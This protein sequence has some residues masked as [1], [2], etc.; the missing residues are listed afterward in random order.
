VARPVTLSTSEQLFA[1]EPWPGFIAVDPAAAA[2]TSHWSSRFAA[3]QKL[4]RVTGAVAFA[5]ASA[6]TAYGPIEVFILRAAGSTWDW[7]PADHRSTIRFEPTQFAPENFAV[8]RNL[9]A[10]IVMVV[11]R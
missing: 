5:R 6:H 1:T 9:P 7:T 10:G 4:S 11:R 3:L 2:G 8:F